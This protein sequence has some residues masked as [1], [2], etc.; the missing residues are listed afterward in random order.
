MTLWA[1]TYAL[2][3]GRGLHPITRSSA[4]GWSVGEPAEV[5]AN[6]SFGTWSPKH[7]LHYLVDEQGGTLGA[8]RHDS[9]W[10]RL[11]AVP[12]GGSQPCH[13]ALSRNEE[14]IAVANYGDGSLALFSLDGITGLPSPSPDIYRNSG[15]GPHPDRQEGPH[16]HCVTFD[17]DGQWLFQVDLG[18][19]QILAFSTQSGLR[20]PCVAFR[21]PPSSGPRHLIFHPGSEFCFLVSE[22]ASTVQLLQRENETL[23]SLQSL[24]TLPKEGKEESLGGH[25][26]MNAGGDR[27]YVT[28]RGHDSVATFAFDGEKLS[29]LQHR[30]SGGASPR[31]FLLIEDQE[32]IVLANEEG[33]NVTAFMLE[34][35]GTLGRQIFD[36]PVPGAAFL[37]WDM[38][39]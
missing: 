5:A 36:L 10:R 23:R 7:R 22:L 28:N 24:S 31:F 20:D 15:R 21:A 13:V 17:Y 9:G 1:G 38:A 16:A 35:D 18:T 29:L 27:L 26:G 3:G 8:Y 19:D 2:K 11:A 6:A 32:M 25:I 4:G 39:S 34:S 33:G 14:H 30:A 37:F 12:T